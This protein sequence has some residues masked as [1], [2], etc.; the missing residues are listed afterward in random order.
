MNKIFSNKNAICLIV[1]IAPSFFGASFISA[2]SNFVAVPTASQLLSPQELDAI[3]RQPIAKTF[4][5][6]EGVIGAQ[7]RDSSFLYREDDG[8][9][10]QEYRDAGQ[11]VDIRVDSSIGTSYQMSP[12]L[13][14]DLDRSRQ[15]LNRVP[16]INLPF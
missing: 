15:T 7:R 2:Q 9:S 4:S 6:K 12:L 13:E 1:I 3:N 14:K 11:N 10:V 16:S 8:T 5:A